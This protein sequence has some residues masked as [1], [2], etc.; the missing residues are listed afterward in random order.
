[1]IE[2]VI[3]DLGGVYFTDG[4][5]KAIEEI[6]ATYALPVDR[7]RD[8]VMGDLGSR[9]RFGKISVAAFWEGALQSWQLQVSADEIAPIWL[10]A[11]EPIEGT[12]LLIDR[13]RFAGY[14]MLFL[15][16]SGST[17]SKAPTDFCTAL[18][19]AY[20]RIESA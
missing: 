19:M 1:M 4:S 14:E 3:C 6:S 9:Y 20:S 5:A 15:S 17:T 7:V 18:Q 11:Y 13:L 2:T 12:V 10:R 8:V 16:R